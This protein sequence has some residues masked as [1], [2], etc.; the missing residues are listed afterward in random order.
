MKRTLF[1]FLGLTVGLAPVTAQNADEKKATVA[2]VQ[3]LQGRAGGF[4]AEKENPVATVMPR[5]SLRATSTCLRALKYLGSE[6]K[7]PKA[8][9]TFVEGCFDKKAGGFADSPGAAVDVFTTAIGIMA[10]VEAKLP[11]D[12]YADD[13]V[14]YLSANARSF[15]DVRIAAAGLEAIKKKPADPAAWIKIVEKDRNE[16]GT[17]GKG[18]GIARETGSAVAALLRLDAKLAK[19]ENVVKALKTGQRDDGGWGKADAKASD[20]ETSYRVMRAFVMLKEKP[21]AARLRAFVAKCRNAD[22]GYGVAPGQ[23]SA[24]GG[25][26]FAVILTKWLDEMK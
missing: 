18:A 26:Y 21:D 19:S 3:A 2:Y 9:A 20:L 24:A 11:T 14:K 10:V 5:P 7:D 23:K 4:L 16:D 17:W 15:E 8:A 1:L 25:T 22:G 13:V 12:P 6:A